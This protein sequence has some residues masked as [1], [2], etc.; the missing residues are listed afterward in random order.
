MDNEELSITD[1]PEGI[2]PRE[3]TRFLCFKTW[4]ENPD[5]SLTD[6]AETCHTGKSTVSTAISYGLDKKWTKLLI[7]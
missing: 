2:E 4:L 1:L 3:K 5:L 6:I 7:K